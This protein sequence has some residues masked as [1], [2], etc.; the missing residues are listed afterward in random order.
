MLEFE[1]KLNIFI[2]SLGK[3]CIIIKRNIINNFLNEIK[4]MKFYPESKNSEVL[5]EKAVPNNYDH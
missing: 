5:S 3:F 1:I 2:H 4:C